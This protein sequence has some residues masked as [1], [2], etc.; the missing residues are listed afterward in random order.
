MSDHSIMPDLARTLSEQERRKLLRKLEG[1]INIQTGEEE[2]IYK[3]QVEKDEREILVENDIKRAGLFTR[4]RLWLRSIFSGR[5]TKETFIGIRLSQLKS[6]I[7]QN[8]HGIAGFDTRSLQPECGEIVFEVYTTVFPLIKLYGN[9]WSSSKRFENSIINLMEKKSTGTKRTVHDFMSFEEMEKI[10][11]RTSLKA[12]LRDRFVEKLEAYVK[13]IPENLFTQ[14]EITI[15]PIYYLKDIVLFPYTEFFKLFH[16]VYSKKEEKPVFKTASAVVALDYLERLYYAVY[17]VSK[18]DTEIK[19]DPEFA[20]D[21]CGRME[22]DDQDYCE[23]L[24]GRSIEKVLSDVIL[25]AGKLGK[26]IPFVELIRYFREDPYYQLIFYIPKLH[27]SEFYLSKLK[28]ELLPRLDELFPRVRKA[29]IDKRTQELFPDKRLEPLLYY[30]NYSSLDYQKLGLPTFSHSKSINLL[31]NFIITYYRKQMQQIIQIL[32]Q[33]LLKQNR[34]TLNRLMLNS[35]AIED[36]EEKIKAFDNSLSP[37]E[38][39]GKLFQRIRHSIGSDSSH[40]RLY[41]SLLQQKDNEVKGLLEKGKESF[42]GIKKIFDEFIE[43]PVEA[44]KQKLN[45]HY[46]IDGDS[47]SLHSVL[48]ERSEKIDK[49]RNL[50][51]ETN[52]IERNA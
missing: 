13:N 50:L 25:A 9:L 35:A 18:I 46:F 12:E 45:T 16:Y 33:S 26:K 36:L 51:Y 27:L 47:K 7:K 34:I 42:L 29:V 3:K 30:R 52:K 19:L 48:K 28:L 32:G 17:L 1:S 37:E 8:A 14:V 41:R 24:K 38:E 4:F 22:D 21:L 31:Y 20:E 2:S 40:Q 43:S 5:D 11:T 6:A 49:F 44:V 10:Y 39:D 23:D 15:L